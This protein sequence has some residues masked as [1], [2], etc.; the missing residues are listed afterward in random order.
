MNPT[1]YIF[2]SP[3]FTQLE[4]ILFAVTHFHHSLST[5]LCETLDLMM[6]EKKEMALSPPTPLPP[7]MQIYNPVI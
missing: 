2:D 1:L 4:K 5:V 7:L 3:V 6:C